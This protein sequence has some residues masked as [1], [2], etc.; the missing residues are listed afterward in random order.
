MK[1]PGGPV[2]A[3][4]P[5]LLLWII[6][7]F[8][9]QLAQFTSVGA[10]AK[11]ECQSERPHAGPDDDPTRVAGT[12]PC[13]ASKCRPRP[14]QRMCRNKARPHSFQYTLAADSAADLQIDVLDQAGNTTRTMHASESE[15][16]STDAHAGTAKTLRASLCSTG[17][18]HFQVTAT[19]KAGKPVAVAESPQGNRR[20][21]DVRWESSVLNAWAGT[22][23]NSSA[24]TNIKC[25]K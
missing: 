23:S 25:T 11:H 17:D 9:Q 3:P 8:T 1:L 2:G 13:L 10:V 7:Q 24:L 19:D 15:S 22:G 4:E 16:W 20:R 5:P 6:L 21:R 12:P 18:Y 14:P